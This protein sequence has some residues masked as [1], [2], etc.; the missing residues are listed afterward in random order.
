M[1]LWHVAS[2]GLTAALEEWSWSQEAGCET[3]PLICP[4]PFHI[5][6]IRY[7]FS[8]KVDYTGKYASWNMPQFNPVTILPGLWLNPWIPFFCNKFSVR[9]PAKRRINRKEG[10]CCLQVKDKTLKEPGQIDSITWFQGTI[11]SIWTSS[12]FFRLRCTAEYDKG[13]P[14]AGKW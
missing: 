1:N 4:G 5:C 6:W 9:N 14:K 13:V 12:S 2:V 7:P 11:N 10:H 8:W 3:G